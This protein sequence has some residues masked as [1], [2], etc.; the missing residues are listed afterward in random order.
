MHSIISF[1]P[2]LC[3][4][5]LNIVI[6]CN[7]LSYILW[8][9][10]CIRAMIH[11][12]FFFSSSWFHGYSFLV[13]IFHVAF[14]FCGVS[15]FRVPFSLGHVVCDRQLRVWIAETFIVYDPIG[16]EGCWIKSFGLDGLNARK[17]IN[18]AESN[19]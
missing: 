15:V 11:V 4:Y 16:F 3:T 9:F 7:C 14:T 18:K 12:S 19:L 13:A 8:F 5:G 2:C 10:K 1:L 6:S 17:E